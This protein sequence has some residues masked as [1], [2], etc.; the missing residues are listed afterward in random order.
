MRYAIR[1]RRPD[2]RLNTCGFKIPNETVLVVDLSFENVESVINVVKHGY[3]VTESHAT[4]GTYSEDDY[5]LL[6]TDGKQITL[7]TLGI[8]AKPRPEL[9][10]LEGI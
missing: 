1:K 3:L 5:D 8:V 4:Q 10:F 7:V 9:D 6:G 2:R